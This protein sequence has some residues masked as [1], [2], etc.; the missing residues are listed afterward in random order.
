MDPRGATPDPLAALGAFAHLTAARERT[1]AGLALQARRLRSACVDAGC[2]AL[3]GS[4]GRREVTSGSDI[5]WLLLGEGD[6]DGVRATLGSA[7][8]TRGLFNA[9]VSVADLARVGAEQD[10]VTNLTRRLLLLIESVPVVGATAHRDA[11]RTLLTAYLARERRDRRPPRFLLNDLVR[12]WRTIAV[13]FEGKGE[14]KWALRHAKL[15]TS[16]TVLF[17]GGLLPLLECHHVD[18]DAVPGLL[19]DRYLEPPVDRLAR[20]FATYDAHDAGVRTLA[21]YDAFLALLDDDEQRGHLVGL[22]RADAASDPV[23]Q[24]ARR[25]GREV[26][27]GLLAL[28]FE[29]EPL[30]RLVRQYLIF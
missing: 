7:E 14:H 25:L 20:A 5:D 23:F 6:E 26:Q 12:Y 28:L 18:A 15:R 29:R 27:Q 16:R 8:G 1:V 21:A 4:W 2:V 19:L 10:D 22:P 11:L 13:E 9:R 30:R 3:M 24:E 17:A